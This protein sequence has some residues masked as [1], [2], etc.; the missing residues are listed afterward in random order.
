MGVSGQL[1][2]A[3]LSFP[4]EF[5]SL[6]CSTG[7]LLIANGFSNKKR[8]DFEY[9]S[10]RRFIRTATALVNPFLPLVLHLTVLVEE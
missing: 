2:P 9:I 6:Y 3:F 7:E 1:V 8:N 10:D 5:F 4:F